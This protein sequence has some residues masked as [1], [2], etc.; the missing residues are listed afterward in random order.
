MTQPIAV[1]I[2]VFWHPEHKRWMTIM[3]D[4]WQGLQ[5]TWRPDLEEVRSAIPLNDYLR[6]MGATWFDT[7]SG[8]ENEMG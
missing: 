8:T 1:K 4:Y 5:D 7:K 2:S 3:Q 6:T